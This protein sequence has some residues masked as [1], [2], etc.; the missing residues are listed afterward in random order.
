MMLRHFYILTDKCRIRNGQ[1]FILQAI[2]GLSC[3]GLATKGNND[4]ENQWIGLILIF[5]K[6]N[7]ELS[8]FL[9]IAFKAAKDYIAYLPDR[10]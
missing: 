7:K 9:K 3:L 5:I 6:L 8:L 1:F 10:K 2:I 4:N